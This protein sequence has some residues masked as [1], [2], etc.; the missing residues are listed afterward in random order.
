[1]RS[2]RA[3]HSM[4]LV[5]IVVLATAGAA[6]A[7]NDQAASTPERE[8][9]APADPGSP[10][11]VE[12]GEEESIDEIIVVG[13]KTE[14]QLRREIRVIETRILDLF[15]EANPDD[16][17]DIV[18]HK[19]ARV[20]SQIPRTN[21]KARTYWDALAELAQDDEQAVQTNRPLANP[22][23]HAK[24]LRGKMLETAEENP[25]LLQALVERKL[26]QRQLESLAESD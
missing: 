7:Q 26:L 1:M 9:E 11:L 24:V 22:A 19:E 20:G 12:T 14:V 10:F 16:D 8:Q 25:A 23:R 13:E 15:N 4:H 3:C 2:L 17:Y 21:C 5:A 18:C 6:L